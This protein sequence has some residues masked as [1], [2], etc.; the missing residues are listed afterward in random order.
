[1]KLKNIYLIVGQSGSGKDTITDII[2]KEYGLK[3]VI[4]FTTRPPRNKSEIG[5]SHL[6][7]TKAEFDALENK[8]AYTFY[9]NHEYCATSAQVDECDLYIIDPKGV[10]YLKQTYTGGK[11]VK[12]IYIESC[13]SSRY[14][15]MKARAMTSNRD[16]TELQ[17]V[18]TALDRVNND[19]SDFY[20]YEHNICPVDYRVSNNDNINTPQ[21]VADKI[22]G[23]IMKCENG[24][25]D[26]SNG[27][28][29]E[30]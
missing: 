6:F 19:V 20:E 4:S 10:K 27:E 29:R 1:M 9:N 14:E 7:V 25:V 8:V 5:K 13:Y 23:F 22:F 21:E 18:N 2:C 12:V 26:N 17:A 30:N 16:M 28:R 24:D 15:R 11:G 3:K